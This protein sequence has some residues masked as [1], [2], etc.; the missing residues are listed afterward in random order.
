MDL[1]SPTI[2]ILGL[3]WRRQPIQAVY[4][5]PWK[6]MQLGHPYV[7][8]LPNKRSGDMAGPIISELGRI[9]R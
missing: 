7:S 1:R 6:V 4:K 8:I 9:H 3:W 2:V 5:P